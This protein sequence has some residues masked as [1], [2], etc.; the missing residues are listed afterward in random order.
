[1]TNTNDERFNN[2]DPKIMDMYYKG[3][4]PERQPKI[5]VT[6]D[7]NERVV[8]AIVSWFEVRM[9]EELRVRNK[10][11]NMFSLT[12]SIRLLMKEAPGVEAFFIRNGAEDFLKDEVEIISYETNQEMEDRLKMGK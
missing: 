8:Q 12:D 2:N 1:M 10:E 3:Q 7:W 4:N 11:T 6:T 5:K 9:N